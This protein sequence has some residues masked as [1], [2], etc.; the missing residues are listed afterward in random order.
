MSVWPQRRIPVDVLLDTDLPEVGP[1]VRELTDAGADGVFTFEGP[2]D[3]FLPLGVA[4]TVP[5]R[6]TLYTNL[7]IALPRSPMHLAQQA[8]DL[9]RA[10]GGRFMLGLG[11]QVRRHVE[12][13]Y[14][15]RWESPVEQMREWLLA[16]QAIFAAWQDR[17]PLAFEGR[18]TRH[19]YLP[20]LFDPGPLDSGPPPLVIGAV[21]PRMLRLA[22]EV[23]DGLLVHPF[24][25][26]RTMDEHTLPAVSQ[27]LAASGRQRE[28]FLVIGQ[29]MVAVGR[30]DAERAESLGRARAQ[31]GFYA[32]TPAYRV[33][34]DVHGWGDLQPTL[35]QLVRE[36]RWQELAAQ[37]PDEVVDAFVCSGSPEDVARQVATRAEAVD[38]VAL[39]S[40]ASH[41]ARLALLDALR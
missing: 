22:S 19:T 17:V 3:A 24:S 13:R 36:Q 38:R 32:S 31:V 33:M 37:V 30:D 5:G 18:W 12:Q 1:R 20:P 7:A 21:G 6:A 10:S 25:T 4:A 39:S 40:F 27:G 41:E 9:Q 34:L 35:Q 14:G 11:T 23:A 28:H 26:A 16:V 8:W 2:R 29:V 15:T